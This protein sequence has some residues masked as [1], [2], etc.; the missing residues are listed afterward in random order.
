MAENDFND[1][2]FFDGSMP[3]A[4]QQNNSSQ[5]ELSV[6]MLDAM[7]NNPSEHPEVKK[8]AILMKE[9]LY[10]HL[11]EPKQDATAI[12][13]KPP[14]Q[15]MNQNFNNYQQPVNNFV[16]N[17]QFNQQS[18]PVASRVASTMDVNALLGALKGNLYTT[19]V[20]LLSNERIVVKLR[21]MTVQEYKFLSKQLEIFESSIQAI[22]K[23]DPEARWKFDVSELNLSNS[24]KT[25]LGNCITDVNQPLDLGQL[26]FFDWVYLLLVLRQISRGSSTIWEITCTNKKCKKKSTIQIDKII[27]RM[28]SIDKRLY[29][30]T[31]KEIT[32]KDI[33][34]GLSTITKQDIDFMEQYIL[35][36]KD[37]NMDTMTVACSVKYYEMNGVRH[38]LEPDQRFLV[39]NSF[40]KELMEDVATSVSEHMKKFTGCFG[41]ISCEHCGKVNTVTVSDFFFSYFVL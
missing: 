2:V 1:S 19:E 3:K 30:D 17:Q 16:P 41:K 39:F 4:V 31:F 38:I 5:K 21:A 35:H 7:I 15:P 36:N 40:S 27:E 28:Q 25:V 13:D 37:Q 20:T 29:Q 14:A 18:Q 22:E 32:Y 34:L 8:N 24:L 10:G 26:T 11:I 33:K 23:N 9:K 12:S 6:E